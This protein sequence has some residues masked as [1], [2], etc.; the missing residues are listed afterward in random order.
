M[1]DIMR[2]LRVVAITKQFADRR[3]HHLHTGL[4]DDKGN[5]GTEPAVEL[6]TEEHHHACRDQR[7]Q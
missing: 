1:L 5:G 6:Q 3:Q 7:R 4:D 2:E